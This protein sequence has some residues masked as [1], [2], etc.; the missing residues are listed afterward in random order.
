MPG[1]FSIPHIL[2]FSDN[3]TLAH[4]TQ[5]TLHLSSVFSCLLRI[6]CFQNGLV[7]LIEEAYTSDLWHSEDEN[8]RDIRLN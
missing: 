5:I 8:T 1:L 7:R 4:I 2:L 3:I 6:I